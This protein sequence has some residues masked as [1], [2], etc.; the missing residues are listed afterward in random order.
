M[1]GKEKAEQLVCAQSHLMM[2]NKLAHSMEV[3]E[4]KLDFVPLLPDLVPADD[5]HA[6]K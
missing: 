4:K 3:Q 5:S 6:Q 2:G 1:G